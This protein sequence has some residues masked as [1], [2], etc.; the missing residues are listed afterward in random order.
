M[1]Y[2][3][4]IIGAGPAGLEAASILGAN[5]KK[6][7]IVEADKWGGTCL[8][9]GCIPTKMLLAPASLMGEFA[10]LRRQKEVTGE[11]GINYEGLQKRV[12]R[13]VNAT[14]AAT[15]QNLANNAIDTYNGMARLINSHTVTVSGASDVE[16]ELETEWIILAVGSRN[17]VFNGLEPDHCH[18]LDST[19]ILH[20][21]EVPESLCIIGAGAIGLEFASFFSSAGSQITL[22][23]AAA[24]I[25][26]SEDDDIASLLAK[27][28]SKR[29][30]VIHSGKKARKLVTENDSAVLYLE[31]GEQVRSAKALVAIGRSGCTEDMGLQSAGLEVSARGFVKVDENLMAAP[32]IF[33]VGDCNGKILLAHAA[34]H[35][36]AYVA[37]R[38]MGWQKTPYISGPVPACIYGEPQIMRVGLT[39]REASARGKAEIS[40]AELARNPIA[41]AHGDP[42]GFVKVV[43]LD[44]AIAGISAIGGNVTNLVTAAELMVAGNYQGRGLDEIMIA[45][46]TLDES[47]AQAIMA[48]KISI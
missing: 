25:A 5:G 11:V 45:H 38:I 26:P 42:L 21:G 18:I 12:W 9:A 8:N 7:A 40:I 3:V 36:A 44:G 32:N 29:G 30:Y 48:K 46:P 2:D 27:T 4:I 1:K 20:L 37:R 19:D 31:D 47:L 22:V 39:A 35:Q 23:E 14:S 33:A 34:S 41:Q 24:H 43:W 6:T 17:A 16:Q 10:N 28:L 15:A 13:F